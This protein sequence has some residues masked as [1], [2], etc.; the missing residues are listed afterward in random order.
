MKTIQFDYD[1]RPGVSRIYAIPVTSFLRLRKNYVNNTTHLEVKDRDAI[2][3][4]PINTLSFRFTENQ[5]SDEPGET[6][7][8]SIEGCIPKLSSVNDKMIRKLERGEW[9]VLHQDNNGVVH[10]SGTIAVPLTFL[11]NKTTGASGED[12]N[13][14]SFIFSAIT[15]EPSLIINM[16]L[17]TQL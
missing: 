8:P 7:H 13:G 17:I 1:N 2:I 3:D 12:L 11:S 9:L 5:T 15:P 16:L 6:Y 4:I 14:N 10:L